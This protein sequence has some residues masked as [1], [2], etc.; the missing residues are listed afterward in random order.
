MEKLGIRR[1]TTY[2]TMNDEYNPMNDPNS[3][4]SVCVNG[5]LLLLDVTE[6]VEHL[7]EVLQINTDG[8]YM[9]VDS[10]EKIEEIKSICNEW[11]TRIGRSL[12]VGVL[13]LTSPLDL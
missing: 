13:F 3:A 7:G 5:Q 2:G 4:N 12:S 1:N 10:L 11:E 6:K 8:V 9:S